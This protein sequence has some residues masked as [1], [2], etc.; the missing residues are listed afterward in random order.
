MKFGIVGTGLIAE[1]HARAIEEI[2]G[3]SIAACLDAVPE[4][5]RA[6]AAK[7]GCRA[8]ED[9]AAFLADPEIEIV[10]ICSPSGAHLD[11]ALPAAESGRHL[12]VEKPLEITVERCMR[13]V[14]AADKAKVVL[15]GIFPSRFHEA[16]RTVKEAADSKR[17]GRLSMGNAYVKWW[18]EQ[19]YYS[20]SGWKGTKAMDG[21]GALMNQSIHAVDLLLWYM[22]KVKRVSAFTGVAGHT[23]LEVEDNA[24]AALEFECGALGSIQGSTAVWP[25]FLKRVEVLGTEGSA[26]LEEESLAFW[27]FARELPGDEEARIRFA[28]TTPTRGGASDPSAISHRGHRLQ[29][30]DVLGAIREGR[31]PL[32]DGIEATRPVALIR[33]IYES[34]ETGRPA[35][36]ADPA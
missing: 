19:T 27:R 7:H 21:G 23:G 1:F 13:I 9:I 17:F 22:G 26:I 29:I 16:A 32:V 20:G 8:Y 24:T 18:R 12:I 31:K 15:S 14:Q 36:P 28:S 4:R 34:A 35:A 6:F 25:G 3:S 2:P 11:A 5:A 30:E 33:A 10:N